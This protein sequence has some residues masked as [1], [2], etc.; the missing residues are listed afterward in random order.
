M[1]FFYSPSQNGFY[2]TL[3]HES[4]MPEDAVAISE[5]VHSELLAA[6]SDGKTIRPAANGFPVAIALDS[7]SE[8]SAET[9]RAKRDALLRESDWVSIRALERNIAV[10]DEWV[11]YRQALRDLPMQ[12]GF[13]QSVDWPTPPDSPVI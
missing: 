13:P 2:N 12:R 6:Q 10:P 5:Q 9:V 1:D 8:D 11:A 3:I 7:S 4:G